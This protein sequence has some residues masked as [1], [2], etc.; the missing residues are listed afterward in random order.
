M[1]LYVSIS[2]LFVCLVLLVCFSV[3]ETEYRT[4]CMLINKCSG[5]EPHPPTLHL[6]TS[7]ELGCPWVQRRGG[8]QGAGSAG[9]KGVL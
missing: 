5:P 3:L 9:E 1:K 7:E 2:D 6:L 4:L 8:L